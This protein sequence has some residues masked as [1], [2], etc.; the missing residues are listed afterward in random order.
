[1]GNRVRSEAV[2]VQV[3]RG[4]ASRRLVDLRVEFGRV[5]AGGR[6]RRR[7]VEGGGEGRKLGVAE[8]RAKKH[9]FNVT[10]VGTRCGR[11]AGARVG[12]RT[13]PQSVQYRLQRRD[14]CRC[15]SGDVPK[16]LET[17]GH[18]TEG[19]E[20]CLIRLKG[21]VVPKTEG[22]EKKVSRWRVDGAI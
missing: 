22:V 4:D 10:G 16:H 18:G 8:P 1:V 6:G 3:E 17:D 15:T 19:G 7:S 2:A 5:E 13:R 14:A 11:M 12:A 20:R 21:C 9:G